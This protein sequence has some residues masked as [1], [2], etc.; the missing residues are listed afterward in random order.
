MLSS[1]VTLQG[2]GSES[3]L[4]PTPAKGRAGLGQVTPSWQNASLGAGGERAG[5][6]AVWDSVP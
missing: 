5:V 2:G 6:A 3:V 4:T 1:R